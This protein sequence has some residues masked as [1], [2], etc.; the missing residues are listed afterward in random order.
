MSDVCYEWS[1]LGL[2]R[3]ET[4]EEERKSVQTMYQ[5]RITSHAPRNASGR[6]EED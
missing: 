1:L 5:M 2:M 6:E 3:R 4:G